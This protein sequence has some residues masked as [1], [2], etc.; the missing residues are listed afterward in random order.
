MIDIAPKHVK[1]L[2][3]R[4]LI[5]FFYHRDCSETVSHTL[6][7]LYVLLLGEYKNQLQS[8]SSQNPESS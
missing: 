4:F 2:L 6:S 5:V 8:I 7:I 3:C 1:C